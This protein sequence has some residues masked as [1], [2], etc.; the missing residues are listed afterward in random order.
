MVATDNLGAVAG[1]IAVGLWCEP[2]R[3]LSSRCCHHCSQKQLLSRTVG[4]HRDSVPNRSQY[5]RHHPTANLN[6]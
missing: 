6:E 2:S 4:F 1:L 3:T 5:I